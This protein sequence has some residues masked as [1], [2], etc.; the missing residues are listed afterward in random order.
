MPTQRQ[1]KGSKGGELSQA[2]VALRAFFRI[3]ELWKLTTTEQRALLGIARQSALGRWRTAPPTTLSQET[4]ERISHVLAIYEALQILLPEAGPADR[5][6]KH[7]NEG[8]LFSGKPA[9]ARLMSGQLDDLVVVRRYLEA[10]R[11]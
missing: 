2:N 8:P 6:I 5:W 9:M 3:A 1:P 4:L 10:Q 11:K 7:P